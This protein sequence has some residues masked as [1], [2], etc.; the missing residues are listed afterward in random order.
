MGFRLLNLFCLRTLNPSNKPETLI[1]LF[2]DTLSSLSSWPGGRRKL[3]CP[4]FL[5]INFQTFHLLNLLNS[6]CPKQLL[7]QS[8]IW[9][10]YQ[11]LWHCSRWDPAN[12][13]QET[14][15]NLYY[16][17]SSAM[18]KDHNRIN[19]SRSWQV[20]NSGSRV[21]PVAKREKEQRLEEKLRTLLDMVDASLMMECIPNKFQKE[22]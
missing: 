10:D 12:S 8:F 22:T 1:S 20:S 17:Q 2:W 13:R 9:W 15:N 6:D 4:F 18:Y 19:N 16:L 21:K 5:S 14:T 3:T 7:D 11:Y